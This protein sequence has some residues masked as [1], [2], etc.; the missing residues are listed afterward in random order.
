MLDLKKRILDFM[1]EKLQEQDESRV[2]VEAIKAEINRQIRER[3][4]QI[5]VLQ[6]NKGYSSSLREVDPGLPN[7][8]ADIFRQ[9]IDV[10]KGLDP[11]KVTVDEIFD[12][13][14]TYGQRR[15]DLYSQRAG[16]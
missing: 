5:R 12:L 14:R 7:D 4:S 10:L 11:N 16:I 3:E 2:D 1:E 8:L 13:A 15:D 6:G 9:E